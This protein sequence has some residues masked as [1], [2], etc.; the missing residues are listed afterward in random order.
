MPASPDSHTTG[1]GRLPFAAY[2]TLALAV[3]L[4]AWSGFFIMDFLLS[5]IY[6]WIR[7]S[8]ALALICAIFILSYEFVYKEHHARHAVLTGIAPM[9]VVWYFCV[10]PYLVGTLALLTLINFS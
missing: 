9:K 3:F 8:R 4:C 2:I 5:G 6:T 1:F 10:I 7:S